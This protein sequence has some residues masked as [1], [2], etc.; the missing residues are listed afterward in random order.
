ML[1]LAAGI[2]AFLR[3]SAAFLGIA[4]GVGAVAVAA[5]ELGCSDQRGARD[6]A[7][8]DIIHAQRREARLSGA[9]ARESA[10]RTPNCDRARIEGIGASAAGRARAA[11]QVQSAEAAA[12]LARCFLL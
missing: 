9:R 3:E 5:P 6:L 12:A 11:C 8:E 4:A 2:V 7:D 1:P 10:A